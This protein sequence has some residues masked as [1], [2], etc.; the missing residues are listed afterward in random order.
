MVLKQRLQILVAAHERS[1]RG[2]K[3]AHIQEMQKDI[4]DVIR[5]YFPVKQDQV[6]LNL[7]KKGQFEILELNITLPEEGL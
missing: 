1:L 3:S 6:S 2:R 7:D 4:V 5:K